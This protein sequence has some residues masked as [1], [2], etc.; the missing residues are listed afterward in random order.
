[1]LRGAKKT[2]TLLRYVRRPALD[3]PL[4]GL[5]IIVLLCVMAK[6]SVAL[7]ASF[8][9]IQ[10]KSTCQIGTA[11]NAKR[12]SIVILMTAKGTLHIRYLPPER[13][14]SVFSFHS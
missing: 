8:L 4:F 7:I 11:P 14:F 5:Q 3:N 2:V 1:M 12:Q 9:R 6:R 13:G 10:S